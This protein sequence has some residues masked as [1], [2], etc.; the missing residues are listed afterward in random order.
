M[1]T[2]CSVIF[3]SR[4]RLR[5]ASFQKFLYSET[6]LSNTDVGVSPLKN[7]YVSGK[8]YPS[9]VEALI[10]CFF[11]KR[12]SLLMSRISFGSKPI[13]SFKCAAICFTDQPSNNRT[14]I[15]SGEP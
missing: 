2:S 14:F 15:S 1:T 3:N 13:T 5:N 6:T 12:E 7:K 4:A 8:R 11:K 10:L 9:I